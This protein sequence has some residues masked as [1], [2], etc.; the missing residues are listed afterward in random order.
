MPILSGIEAIK[1]IRKSDKTTPI[2]AYSSTYQ[3]DMSKILNNLPNTYYCQKSSIIIKDILNNVIFGETKNYENYKKE[4]AGQSDRVKEY[5]ERQK[6]AQKD[7]TVL[8][9]HIIKLCYEGYSNKEIGEKIDLST[10]TVDTYINRLTEK[11][12]LKN[13]LDLVRFCVE[14]GYYNTDI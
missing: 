10:R 9:I 3:E 7:L 11:L 14:N 1:F 2:L 8:E 12:E 13:K 6:N 4:W 5:M